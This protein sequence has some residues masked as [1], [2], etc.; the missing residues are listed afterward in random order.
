MNL[1]LRGVAGVQ[2]VIDVLEQSETIVQQRD[3]IAVGL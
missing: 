1:A 3:V 2:H